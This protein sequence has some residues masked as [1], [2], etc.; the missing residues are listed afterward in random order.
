MWVASDASAVIQET[1]RIVY[2]EDGEYAIVTPTTYTIKSLTHEDHQRAPQDVELSAE[3][4]EKKGYPHFM[5]KEIMEIPESV[6]NTLRGRLAP[7]SANVKLGGLDD[8]ERELKATARLTIVGCGSAYYAGL[9]G[10]YLIEDLVGV[11]V[12]A[13][14][15]SEERYRADVVGEKSVL[16]AVSQSGETADTL[17]AVKAAKQKGVLTLGLVNVVGSTIARTTDA[18]VYTHAGPEIGVASTKAYISQL[19]GLGLIALRLGVLRGSNTLR[20]TR[21]ARALA[22]V[23]LVV[24]DVLAR[25]EEIRAAAEKY[26]GTRHMLFLG[27]RYNAP[28]AYEGALKLKE[29][30]YIHAE[31]YPAGEMKHGPLAMI[32]EDFPVLAIAPTDSVYEKMVS[33]IQEIKARRG[34][35]IMLATDGDQ[36]ATELDEDVLW[37]PK[38]DEALSPIAAAVT[39]Q[40]FAYYAGT[41]LGYDVD[42]PRNL[43]KSVTVE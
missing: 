26:R 17:A 15:G 36:H 33:N 1:A 23:P 30:S 8:V 31:G 22:T 34:P 2:L 5:L 35:V 6:R 24:D 27:R 10:K 13:V 40:L 7:G 20:L 3:A 4:L 41:S 38:T 42:R 39:L 43:A 28:T 12:D 37:L 9:Y 14:L 25:R 16:L 32:D 21:F 19:I 18:G 11:P 29:V